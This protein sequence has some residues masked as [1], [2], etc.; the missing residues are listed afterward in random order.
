MSKV[1]I[2]MIKMSKM[3]MPKTEVD[4]SKCFLADKIK[5]ANG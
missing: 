4:T 5:T 1:K 2:P 3:E